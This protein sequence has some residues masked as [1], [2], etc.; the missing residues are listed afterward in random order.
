MIWMRVVLPGA[1][2]CGTVRAI[3]GW[4][5]TGLDGA[6]AATDNAIGSNAM[7]CNRTLTIHLLDVDKHLRANGG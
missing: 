5:S 7:G 6:N 3:A 2:A 1:T 4:A